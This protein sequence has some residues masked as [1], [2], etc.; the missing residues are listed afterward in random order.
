MTTSFRLICAITTPLQFRYFY[1]LQKS[2]KYFISNQRIK[3]AEEGRKFF[4][5]IENSSNFL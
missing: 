2:V 4:R 1:S 5:I 3:S